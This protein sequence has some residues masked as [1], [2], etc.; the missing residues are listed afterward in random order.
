MDYINANIFFK[1][2]KTFRYCLMYGIKR[3]F[4]KIKGQYHMSKNFK[5]LPTNN[6]KR[7]QKLSNVGIVG[8][9]NFA[10]SNI[11]YYINS[12]RRNLIRTVMDID[13]NKA[14]SL[15][16]EYDCMSYTDDF[17]I[18]LNDSKITK[19]FIASNH[20]THCDY[21]SRCIQVGKDVHIE[22]PHVVSKSQLNNLIESALSNKGVNIFLGFNRT[23]SK[24][25]KILKNYLNKEKGPMMINWFIAGHAIEDD[26]WYF[27]P[28]EGG[29]VL[30]NLCH[31]TDLTLDMIGVINAF[32]C[33]VTAIS[34]IDA[35]S[36]FVI[37]YL[38]ADNSCATISFSAKGHTFEGVREVLNIHRGNL[39]GK[40]TDFHKLEIDIND[41]KRV[42]KNF[43]RDHGHKSNIINSL[44]SKNGEKLEYVNA[45]AKLFLASKEAIESG[46]TITIKNNNFFD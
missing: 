40:L 25:Y 20:S 27:R 18:I 36:D 8:C 29:R 12:Y 39:L 38:F 34:G 28:E 11:A 22:K 42:F 21:A 14:A 13:V 7:N 17:N 43:Y 37:S 26:H 32:P 4:V 46:K 2:K 45:T 24:L 31:W 15:F 23:K 19:V 5:I 33:K 10:F 6:L 30:G 35:K 16:K 3:T 41:F 9:G 44:K 1:L